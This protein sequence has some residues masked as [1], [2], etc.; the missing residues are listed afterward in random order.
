MNKRQDLS[1]IV[2]PLLIQTLFLSEIQCYDLP[3]T[4]PKLWLKNY[5]PFHTAFFRKKVMTLVLI[6]T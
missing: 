4:I 5:V 6:Y 1:V 2:N 3:R